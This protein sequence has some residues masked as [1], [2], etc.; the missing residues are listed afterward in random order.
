MRR[1]G[2]AVPCTLSEQSLLMKP[3]KKANTPT[4]ALFKVLHILTKHKKPFKKGDDCGG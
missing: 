1:E 4:E 3:V 2:V